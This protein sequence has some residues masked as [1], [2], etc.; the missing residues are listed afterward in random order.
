MIAFSLLNCGLFYVT[1]IKLKESSDLLE[2]AAEIE[3][4]LEESLPPEQVELLSDALLKSPGVKS[5]HYISKDSAAVLFSQEIGE[6]IYRILGENPLPASFRIG[7]D[8]EML[9]RSSIDTL[10]ALVSGLSGVDEVVAQREFIFDLFQY[11]TTIWILY[12]II[13]V[14]FISITTIL[15]LN[16][17]KLSIISRKK[18]IE[19]MKLVGASNSFIKGPF[20]VEGFVQGLMG[21]FLSGAITTALVHTANYLLDLSLSITT[22]MLLF[23]VM[24]GCFLGVSGS[25]RAVC[26]HING[27]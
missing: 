11:R 6:D 14:A 4:F 27:A 13:G 22:G 3:A 26:K 1:A 12:S 25:Y 8:P 10:V 20:L 7:I 21:G 16:T 5:L 15:I 2:S 17:T 23:M 9:N 24:G 18:S 19:V